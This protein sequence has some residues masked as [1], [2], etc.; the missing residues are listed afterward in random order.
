MT[1]VQ[2]H[3]QPVATLPVALLVLDMQ[4][5][6]L[7]AVA[8]K[9][10]LCKRVSFAISAAQLLGIEVVFTEQVP[11]KLGETEPA[12]KALAAGAH[13]F[14]KTAF[15]AFG[16]SGLEN[17]LRG[18][19]IAHL[20]IIGIET[21]ICVYQTAT[22]ALRSD[23][24]VTLL[25]DAISCRRGEDAAAVLPALREAGAHILPAETVFYSIL[26]DADDPR[27]REFTRLVKSAS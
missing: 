24:D 7:K 19:G 6:F 14:P 23:F 26:Q 10:A 2:I 25:S 9:D 20:L 22:E 5:G 18:R 16:A 12:L 15:S 17:H 4:A 3:S 1:K 21:P 8:D 11:D 27:F 13:V